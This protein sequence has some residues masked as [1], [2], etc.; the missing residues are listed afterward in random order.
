VSVEPESLGL[1]GLGLSELGTKLPVA[2]TSGHVLVCTG[3]RCAG[4]GS[5]R[6]FQQAWAAYEE[7]RIAYYRTG[8][9]VRLTEAGCLGACDFGPNIAVY[10]RVADGT[11]EESWIGNVDLAAIT[12]IGRRLNQASS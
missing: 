11:S 8:G 5:Q 6:L 4:R 10:A 7:Q 3:T 9:S 12:E 1:S 2:A